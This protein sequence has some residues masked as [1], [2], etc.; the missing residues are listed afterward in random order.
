M[1]DQVMMGLKGLA[2][3]HGL[4]SVEEKLILCE[5][6]HNQHNPETDPPLQ[7]YLSMRLQEYDTFHLS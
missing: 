3:K 6:F 4:D 2:D 5:F 7:E 1:D